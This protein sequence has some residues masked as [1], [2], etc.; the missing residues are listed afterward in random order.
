MRKLKTSLLWLCGILAPLSWGGV[1][2]GLV[3]CSDFFDQE[4]DHVVYA[5]KDHLTNWPDTVYSVMGIL[6]K[7]QAVA[8]RT[9]LLGEVRGDLVE[10]TDNASADLR[11]LAPF[12]T[13][14]A[15]TMPSSTTATTSSSMPTPP[16]AATVTSTSS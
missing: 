16:C 6:N 10:L 12:S 8:D 13:S 1:G 15:T 2:G 11:E 3:S 7:L 5:E 14:P 9:I 4:S